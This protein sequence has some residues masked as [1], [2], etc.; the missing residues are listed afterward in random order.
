VLG[1]PRAALS[2]LATGLVEVTK[3]VGAHGATNDEKRHLEPAD[4][5]KGGDPG[6]RTHWHGICK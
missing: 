3:I 6:R 4:R 5:E 1:T 2:S